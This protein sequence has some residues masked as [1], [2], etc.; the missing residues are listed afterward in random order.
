MTGLAKETQIAFI[1]QLK[2]INFIIII[3]LIVDNIDYG[4]TEE[5]TPFPL[6]VWCA[7][8]YVVLPTEELKRDLS[9]ALISSKRLSASLNWELSL[10]SDVTAATFFQLQ[11]LCVGKSLMIITLLP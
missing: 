6:D 3:K 7:F 4:I 9:I 5:V 2:H 10:G 11:T 1:F 8:V